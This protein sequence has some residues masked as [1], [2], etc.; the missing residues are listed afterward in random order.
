MR[1]LIGVVFYNKSELYINNFLNRLSIISNCSIYA[2]FNSSVDINLITKYSNI[3]FSFN[4]TNQGSAGGFFE[5]LAYAR[6]IAEI[7][8]LLTIDDDLSFSQEG[9][10]A[11]IKNYNDL[12]KLHGRIILLG[13]RSTLLKIKLICTGYINNKVSNYCGGFFRFNLS[14]LIY[15]FDYLFCKIMSWPRHYNEFPE[16]INNCYWGGMLISKSA[17][18]DVLLHEKRLFLYKDDVQFSYNFSSMGGKI[19]VDRNFMII[20]KGASW[21]RHKGFWGFLVPELYSNSVRLYYSFRNTIYIQFNT[22]KISHKVSS[23]FSGFFYL[24]VLLIIIFFRFANFIYIM[25]SIR[26]ALFFI[27]NKNSKFNDFKP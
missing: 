17:L 7:D 16:L 1:I 10:L 20:D 22:P 14:H 11:A 25:H 23:F 24:P 15:Y 9:L 19:F 4:D 21:I 26:D 3:Y 6:D 18:F 8:Y 5:I 27:L 2:V 13:F 12:S